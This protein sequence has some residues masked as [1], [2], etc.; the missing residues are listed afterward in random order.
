MCR[1]R[2]RPGPLTA[3]ST[4]RNPPEDPVTADRAL[5]ALQQRVDALQRSLR[6]TRLCAA[7]AFAA[8]AGLSCIAMPQG[9]EAVRTRRVEIVDDQG[10]VRIALGQDPKDTQRRSRACGLTV[11]D[12]TGAERGGFV[13]MDDGSV[14]LGMD[15]PRGVGNAMRDRIGLKVEPDGS[16]Y[17]MLIDNQTLVPVRMQSDAAG[18]GGLE[19]VGYDLD[20]K[21][22]TVKRLAFAGES[23]HE[24][25]LGDGK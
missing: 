22:A 8:L 23:R 11:H 4:G 25:G 12:R 13:T 10:V 17:V 21:V 14:V 16:A 18:G 15:A 19:F 2:G 7:I 5:V 3:P 9:A 6:T 24:V 1:L 20:K